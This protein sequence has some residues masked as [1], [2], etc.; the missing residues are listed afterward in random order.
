MLS[1]RS[2]LEDGINLLNS[3]SL[4][5]YKWKKL[6]GLKT[7]K[8]P[9][10]KTFVDTLYFIFNEVYVDNINNIIC[11]RAFEVLG[12]STEDITLKQLE[13]ILSDQF[14]KKFRDVKIGTRLKIEALYRASVH[15]QRDDIERVELDQSLLVPTNIDYTQ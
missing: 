3:V 7:S 12:L 4:S 11:Y 2:D 5:M 1:V 15:D 13:T 8:N 14:G 6:L 9:E 10:F